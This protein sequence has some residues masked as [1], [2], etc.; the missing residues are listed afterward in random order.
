M[1]PSRA[2]RVLIGDQMIGGQHQHHGIVTMGLR[3]A[4]R[5]CRNRGGGVPAERL[6]DVGGSAMLFIDGTEFVLR[7]EE[8]LPVRDRQD[9]RHARQS[10][11]AQEC[12]L[13]QALTIRQTDERLRMQF[14]RHGPQPGTGATAQDDGYQTHMFL[15]MR[16]K[17]CAWCCV[18]NV[19]VG[20]GR[21][22]HSR[23]NPASNQ[24][25]PG[26]CSDGSSLENRSASASGLP[27]A[28]FAA[29][30]GSPSIGQSIPR[31]GSFHNKLRSYSGYQ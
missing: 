3:H 1:R 2:S 21:K 26:P 8:Q 12:F 24:A 18:S 19:D 22:A 23:R 4:Q 14:T 31:A 9:F 20:S 15:T 5:C 29:S 11:R 17:L 28:S 27:A 7:L 30:I 13:Q 25:R 6:K 16:V 10:R